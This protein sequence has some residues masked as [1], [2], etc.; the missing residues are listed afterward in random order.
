ME[1]IDISFILTFVLSHFACVG[2]FKSLL[3]AK[4]VQI[5]FEPPKFKLSIHKDYWIFLT[6]TPDMDGGLH[7]CYTYM[8]W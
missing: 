6:E 3:K 2:T 8:R 7:E 5:V 1:D 4:V